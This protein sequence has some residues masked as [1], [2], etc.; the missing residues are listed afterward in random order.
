MYLRF[1]VL[2]LY[3]F[4]VSDDEGIMTSDETNYLYKKNH[5]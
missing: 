5:I 2:H 1:R 3:A 4:K